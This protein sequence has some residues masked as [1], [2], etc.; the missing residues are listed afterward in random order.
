[1][2]SSYRLIERT[3]PNPGATFEGTQDVSTMGRDVTNE[4]VLS[5]SEVSRQHSRITR[6]PGGFVLEDLGS[7]NGTFINGE[8]LVAPRILSPGDLVGLGENVTLTFEM[9]ST[10]AAATGLAPAAGRPATASPPPPPRQVQTP[11]S[12]PPA[13]AMEPA[14]PAAPSP[15]PS[16]PAWAAPEEE[17]G[18]PRRWI[19]AGCGCLVLILI[20]G[21]AFYFMDANYPDMLYAP[22]RL[23][24]F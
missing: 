10:E 1:M 11:P 7:T 16:D 22:L 20:C 8:R 23:L 14:R 12:P 21:G 13:P 3:G 24:G 4:V 19:L 2:T 6:T 17:G 18:G 15:G 9:E 5:D